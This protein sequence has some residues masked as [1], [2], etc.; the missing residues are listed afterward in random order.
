LSLFQ[1]F[2]LWHFI[3]FRSGV[4]N[5]VAVTLALFELGYKSGGCRIDSGD[6]AYL[7]KEVRSRLRRVAGLD[8]TLKWMEDIIIVASN[9]I[10]E[11]TIMSLNEQSHE[12]DAFGGG[13]N[14][15]TC[16]KQPALGCVYKLVALSGHPKIKLSQEVSKITIPGRKKCFRLYGKT[17]YAILD[18]MVLEEEP[19]PQANKQ[20]LCRHPFEES[21]R[22]LVVA[23]R[24][25]PLHEV[26]W[27][28]GRIVKELPDLAAIKVAFSFFF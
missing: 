11:E 20:I 8:P 17:G 28:D 13:K 16:Q 24:V 25:E 23:S 9:D 14:L 21:K 10:N 19:E 2:H 27:S 3:F 26:F 18:L 7:S 6:L 5:F 22:A 1:A 4:I 12:N 15:V